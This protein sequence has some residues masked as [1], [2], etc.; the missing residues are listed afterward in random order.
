MIRLSE[1]LANIL[2]ISSVTSDYV[3]SYRDDVTKCAV[4]PECLTVIITDPVE[5]TPQKTTT[6]KA[7]W[8]ESS[9]EG[10]G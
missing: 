3:Y 6:N 4:L 8:A 10:T 9:L 7:K 1:L 2:K 5:K